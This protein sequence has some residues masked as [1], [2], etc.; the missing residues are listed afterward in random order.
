MGLLAIVLRMSP[1][2]KVALC[3]NVLQFPMYYAPV[4]RVLGPTVESLC[5]SVCLC[6]CV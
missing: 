6:V 3:A 2:L 4:F 1:V 5:H